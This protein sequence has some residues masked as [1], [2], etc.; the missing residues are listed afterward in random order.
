MRRERERGA[1]EARPPS[2]SILRIDWLR[3]GGVCS[4]AAR[5]CAPCGGWWWW[6][7]WACGASPLRC[8]RASA[9]M[10]FILSAGSGFASSFFASL[11]TEKSDFFF[12][13]SPL[14]ASAIARRIFFIPPAC[15]VRPPPCSAFFSFSCC[16]RIRCFS[17]FELISASSAS[18]SLVWIDVSSASFCVIFRFARISWMRVLRRTMYRMRS[19]KSAMPRKGTKTATARRRRPEYLRGL[20]HLGPCAGWS[21]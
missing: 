14:P 13:A 7:W 6:W 19:M 10:F 18:S 1:A 21:Q 20:M 3:F 4:S 2:P 15:D 11:R 17:A 16:S 5:L 12:P 9:R 8:C